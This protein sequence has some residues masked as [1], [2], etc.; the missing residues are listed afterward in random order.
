MRSRVYQVLVAPQDV[1]QEEA[2]ESL[3]SGVSLTD[4]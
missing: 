1:S 2:A 4:T 3:L